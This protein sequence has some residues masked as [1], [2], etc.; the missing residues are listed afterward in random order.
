M[1]VLVAIKEVGDPA[2]P[3][4]V[5]NGEKTLNREG[6]A[7]V[8]N[9]FDEI[10]LEEA[11]RLREQGIAGEVV[12]VAFGPQSWE[13]SLRTALAMGADRAILIVS[14]LG[15]EPL[16]VA[17][18][19]SA[20]AKDE[21]CNLLLLGR[22]GVDQ[23]W[24]TTGPMTAGI[25]GWPQATFVSK[26][27]VTRGF[28]DVVREVDGGRH[29]L[30]LSLPA[31]ISVDLGLN[32]PRYASLPNIMKARGQSIAMRRPPEPSAPSWDIV[33]HAP[34]PVR[35]SGRRVASVEELVEQLDRAGVL[36]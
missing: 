24:G 30:R 3:V 18:G 23:D 13:G 7:G 32:T 22:Q 9:P 29:H 11:V 8:I 31:V 34:P 12:V 21:A 28:V 5:G 33:S 35:S 17:K 4:H 10:A 2:V 16:E 14:S 19:L 6:V 36:P 20:C 26:I 1:R 15:C 25:L 27:T